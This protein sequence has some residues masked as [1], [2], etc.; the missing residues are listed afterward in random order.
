MTLRPASAAECGLDDTPLAVID[1]ETT[2]LPGSGE[3]LEVAIVRVE[4]GAPPR[5]VLDTLVRPVGPV[6]G[7]RIHGILDDEVLDAPP[8]QDVLPHVQA[9]LSDC[10]VAA[11]NAGF[12]IGMLRAAGEAHAW[13]ALTALP[14]VC[15]M[16]L[17]QHLGIGRR[18]P[19]DDACAQHRITLSQYHAA[20]SDAHAAALLWNTYR[21][22][23]ADAGV[24]RFGD[25]ARVAPTSRYV[26]SLTA[27]LPRSPSSPPAAPL[28]P[29]VPRLGRLDHVEARSRYARLLAVFAA[30]G[31]ISPSEANALVHFAQHVGGAERF[32]AEL[33]AD[34]VAALGRGE[35]VD[36]RLTTFELKDLAVMLGGVERGETWARFDGEWTIW[37]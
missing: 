37:S 1:L 29:R 14:H 6:K 2:G 8:L 22:A 23:L 17:R 26:A 28:L 35:I 31:R 21:P 13:P 5:I 9:A 24:R 20:A 4:P 25:L 15:L 33:H 27:P 11:Y 10:V 12:D 19:L 36:R 3:I 32:L 16:W 30:D 18:Q 34:L 7:T